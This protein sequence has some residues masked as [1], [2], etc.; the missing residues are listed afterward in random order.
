MA[1]TTPLADALRGALQVLTTRGRELADRWRFDWPVAAQQTAHVLRWL[2]QTPHRP[3]L[4]A[5][6]GG[7]SSGKSTVFD[8]L[9]QGHRAS[10]VTAQGHATTGLILAVHET[11]RPLLEDVLAQ[12]T[13]LPGLKPARAEL[14][15]NVAG[16]PQTLTVVPHAFADLESTWLL[17]TPDFT[18]DAARREGDV[19]LALLPWFDR[20]VVVV[21]HERWF[22][23]QAIAEL[24]TA[25]AQVGQERMVLFNRTREGSLAA[26][27]ESAFE[28][29][30]Q[31]LGAAGSLV[32]EFRRGRGLSVFPPHTLDE[33]RRFCAAGPLQRTP[34]LLRSLAHTAQQ[35]AGQ[36]QERAAR[37]AQ[38]EPALRS[39]V[40]R[41]TPDAWDALTAVMTPAERAQLEVVTRV[42]RWQETSRWLRGQGQRLEQAV[43]RVPVVG[44]WLVGPAAPAEPADNTD[45]PA[46]RFTIALAHVE[47]VRRRQ[48]HELQRTLEGSTFWAELRRWT[49]LE[50]GRLN[51]TITDA[52]REALRQ[53]VHTVD[54]ALAAWNTKVQSECKGWMPHATGAVGAAALGVA[55]V[56]V[57]VPGPVTILT[58]AA[59]KGAIGA[60]LSQLAASAGLGALAGK[61]LGRFVSVVREK[62]LGSPE[63]TQ[64]REAADAY[65]QLLLS[66]GQAQAQTAGAEAA[67]FVLP[68]GDALAGALQQ[69][70]AEDDA[71]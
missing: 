19:L 39:A 9:L 18:S 62:L 68:A 24:R 17:D 35:V 71:A 21:D 13:F 51:V 22:D 30:A 31:Q 40:E 12:G 69:L 33:V 38:L 45:Q 36:N 10:R 27:D 20:L 2:E 59:A 5:V 64:V 53:T 42:L 46:D 66:A 7:A 15:D 1:A 6:V 60:A 50:P 14:D 32:L 70:A 8:N 54:Q 29:Q 4:V 37:L 48:V 49:K 11:H 67:G 34:K 16:A 63:F 57:A 41:A 23:R 3:A 52:D 56:L 58:L 25:S 26:E 61:H 44:R 28:R 55:V 47:S 43:R 65:R